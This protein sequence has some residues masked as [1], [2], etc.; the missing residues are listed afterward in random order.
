MCGI[1][2]T[3][4][5]SEGSYKISKSLLVRMR[6]TMV[7]RGPDG[8]GVWVNQNKTIGLGHRRLAIVDLSE[9][10]GQPMSNSDSSIWLTFNGEIY[11]H[12][13]I[14][15]T[16]I[17]L[18]YTNWKTDHSDTEVL[19]HAFEHWGIDCVNHL[20]GMFAFAIWDCRSEDLWLA[21]DRLGIKPLYYSILSDR[22]SFASEIKALIVDPDQ[23][24][25]INNEALFHYLSFLTSPAPLT[26]FEGIF[27]VPNATWLKIS[28]HGDIK[29]KRYWDPIESSID[30]SNATDIEI[31]TSILNK[32]DTAI[33]RRSVS[34]VP[35]G[36]FLSGGIDSSI[37]AK[38][39]S[40]TQENRINAF[41]ISYPEDTNSYQ[42]EM[43]YARQV[44][45]DVGANHYIKEL[46]YE[47]LNNFLPEMIRLQDEPIG[48][49]VCVP[50]YYV[51]KLAR[52]NGVT[53]CQVGEG[54][55]ELFCGYPGWKRILK[56][57]KVNDLP[58]PN[59]IKSLGLSTLSLAGYK[60]RM[61]YEYLRRSLNNQHIFWGG[62]EAFPD[63]M[64]KSLFCKN[65]VKQFD[66]YSSWEAIKP[67]REQFENHADKDDHLKWMTF[68][69]L[70]YRLPEL[71]LMRVDKM[72]MGTSIEARVPF[73]D[74]S[75]VEL[76]MGIPSS[77][78]IKNGIL[79]YPLK[80][81]VR[82]LVPDRIINRPKQGFG[83][84]MGDWFTGKLMKNASKD[85][86]E[87]CNETD[88]F[89]NKSISNLIRQTNSPQPWYLM[90]LA[91]WW[92]TYVA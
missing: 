46:T 40:N 86:N 70:N 58:V 50:I 89:D 49:P 6:D 88:I 91:M 80:Q 14:K 33:K 39:F 4:A 9:Q 47:D 30:M 5:F 77:N 45:K 1:V 20:I 79:K 15:N 81:A 7:H 29:E 11:N 13:E 71:L 36:V 60:N 17:E 18:G 68:L 78:I 57:T 12:V 51:S 38:L 72:S 83:I 56:L 26:L 23:K 62:A 41:S 32:L 61:Q 24:R 2:G 87:F 92:K 35:M 25:S 64:K 10:A 37:N 67:I 73:L 8:S 16:L 85:I 53:V 59:F 22:I 75:L 19:L 27:K 48:D 43:I 90:N 82:G 63:T 66:G 52:E 54:A 55:D 34:D 84:P 74:H 76:A 42:D 69:D 28:K 21:R 3:L 31:S 65:F 44:A